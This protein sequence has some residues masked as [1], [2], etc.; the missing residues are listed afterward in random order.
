MTVL[1]QTSRNKLLRRRTL[2]VRRYSIRWLQWLI[3][4]WMLGARPWREFGDGME[5]DGAVSEPGFALATVC[6]ASIAYDT[7]ALLFWIRSW[8]EQQSCIGSLSRPWS[9]GSFARLRSSLCLK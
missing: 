1:R 5:V 3:G 6:A 8:E 4:D 9:L 2:S 7:C